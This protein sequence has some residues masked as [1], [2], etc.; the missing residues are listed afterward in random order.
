MRYI[1]VK[2]HM[3]DKMKLVIIILAINFFPE[4]N[5]KD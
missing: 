4:K 2:I 1:T 5:M 3:R